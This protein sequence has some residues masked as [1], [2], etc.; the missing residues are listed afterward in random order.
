MIYPIKLFIDGRAMSKDNEKIFSSRGRPFTSNKFK[1]YANA[2]ARQAEFQM[3]QSGH[4]MFEIPI[5]VKMTF[6]FSNDARLD[7]FNAPKSI[8]DALNGVA[9]KDDR[10]IHQ[11][12]LILG[13]DEKERVEIDIEPAYYSTIGNNNP[14]FPGGQFTLPAGTPEGIEKA[15]KKAVKASGMKIAVETIKPR[16]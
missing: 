12:F 11:G 5:K 7:I 8:C 10:L 3:K 2:V 16:F 14:E 9:W 4:K 13:Y 15:L 6:Y 1:V